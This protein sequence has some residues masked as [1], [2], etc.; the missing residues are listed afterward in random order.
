MRR[1]RLTRAG[2]AEETGISKPSVGE[3]VRRLAATG[4]VADT[5]ERTQGGRGRGRVGTYYALAAATGV[6][7]AVSVEPESVVAESVDAYGETVSRAAEDIGRS[8]TP[9]QVTAALRSAAARV[10]GEGVTGEGVTGEGVT[11]EGV[12]G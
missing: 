8:A 11:G 1:R 10:T 5:G 3:S 12:T 7:L 2:L 4:L 6:A 9:E